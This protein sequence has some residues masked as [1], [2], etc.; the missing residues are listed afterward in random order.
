[1]NALIWV[2]FWIF[3]GFTP[4]F[5]A[6]SSMFPV[7]PVLVVILFIPFVASYRN[8]RSKGDVTGEPLKPIRI[9][10]AQILAIFAGLQLL[11]QTGYSSMMPLYGAVAGS[12]LYFFGRLV[13]HGK[14]E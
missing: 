11:L 13:F 5:I 3:R 14:T 2:T 10:S 12:V 7:I 4:T 1:M 6:F 8:V 9:I